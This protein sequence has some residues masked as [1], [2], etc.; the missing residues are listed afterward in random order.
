MTHDGVRDMHDS[1]YFG[2]NFGLCRKV[3]E[4]VKTFVLEIDGIRKLFGSPLV[5]GF[6]A[7]AVIDNY[8]GKFMAYRRC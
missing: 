7:S 4:H 5:D 1:G 2:G 3:H 8:I 6:Y